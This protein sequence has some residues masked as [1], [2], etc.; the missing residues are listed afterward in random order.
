MHEQSETILDKLGRWINVYGRNT[1]QAGQPLPPQHDFERE[2]YGTVEEAVDA[3]KRRSSQH[4]DILRRL[5]EG[6]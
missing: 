1:P 4:G 3:A 2:S 6:K 5:M